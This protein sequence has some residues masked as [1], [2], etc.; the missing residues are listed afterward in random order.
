MKKSIMLT[1]NDEELIELE[2]I[3]VDN[4]EDGALKFLRKERLWAKKGTGLESGPQY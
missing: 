1:L 4:D 2:R 3:L